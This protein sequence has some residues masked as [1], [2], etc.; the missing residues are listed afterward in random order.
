MLVRG[1]YWESY[2]PA[3]KPEKHRSRDEFLQ[4]VQQHLELTP[5]MNAEDAARAV[6]AAMAQHVSAGELEEVKQ[7]VPEGVRTLFPQG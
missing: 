1:I 6:F 3:G 5:P 2:R 7:M 4:K